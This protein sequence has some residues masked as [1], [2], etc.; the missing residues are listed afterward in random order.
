ME[1]KRHT[2]I[3]LWLLW[4]VVSTAL[5]IAFRPKILR[6][7]EE[8]GVPDMMEQQNETKRDLG[9][10]SVDACFVDASGSFRLFPIRQ[11]M[12][13]GDVYH[14]ALEA[15][16]AGPDETAI[17]EGAATYIAKGT[18]LNGCTLREGALFI[19]LSK[20]FLASPDIKKAYLQLQKTAT[21]FPQVDSVVLLIDG[22]PYQ[23]QT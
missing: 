9:Y 23:L 20:D 1:S 8:S 13:G 6:S 3:L 7:I 16:L 22:E 12:L 2:M 5:V 14:D 4:L 11:R 21:D 18:V 15:L 19:S 10:R 17:G